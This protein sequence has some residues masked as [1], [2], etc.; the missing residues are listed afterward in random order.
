MV[1][2]QENKEMN[3]ALPTQATITCHFLIDVGLTS[4]LLIEFFLHKYKANNC[5][6]I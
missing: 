3:I 6:G 1:S 2:I 4:I 5:A